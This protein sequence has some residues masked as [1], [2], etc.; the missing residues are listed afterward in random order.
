[1]GRVRRTALAGAAALGLAA[2]LPGAA[3][4]EGASPEPG[5]AYRVADG[6]KNVAGKPNSAD[7]PLLVPGTVYE[8]TV[9]PGD[10]FYQLNLDDKSSVYVS[11]VVR[12]LSGAKVGYSDNIEVTVMTT[13]GKTCTNP[14]RASFGNEPVPIG[15]VGVRRLEEDGECTAGGTYYAKVTRTAGKDSDQRSWPVELLVQREPVPGGSNAPTTAPSVWPSASPTLPG[16]KPVG[17]AGGT[18][19]NDA[20]SLGSG[21]WRDDLRPGQTRFYRVPLDW[22]QQLGL[23]AEIAN[24]SMTKDY[25]F[26]A[27]GL[28][29]SLYSPYR[30]LVDSKDTTYDGKQAAVALPRTAPVAYANRFADNAE[31]RGVRLAGWYYIAVTMGRNVGEFIEDAQPVPLTLRMDVIGSPAKGPAY[32]ESLSAAGFGV[33]DDDRAASK[34]GLTAPEAADAA[35]TRSVMRV[36]A[37]AGFGTGTVLLLVL[38]GWILLARRG[39]AG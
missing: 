12:P 1:M 22:G 30:G 33:G 17:R 19:F 2:G 18:G 37:G 31:M 26:A 3:H 34:D 36:V 6:A 24:A 39:R 29:V 8:D 27:A 35:G 4:A 11:A 20:R 7:A 10:R 16:T 25:G 21:V 5:P 38:G 28:K 32:K 23:S 13:G 9:A 14:G 15:A